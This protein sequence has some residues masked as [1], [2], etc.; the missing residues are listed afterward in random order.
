MKQPHHESA[1]E[2]RDADQAIAI[3]KGLNRQ[4]FAELPNLPE[5]R[6]LL[7]RIVQQWENSGFCEQE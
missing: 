6:T 2:R 4:I 3:L 7:R 1:P 5:R